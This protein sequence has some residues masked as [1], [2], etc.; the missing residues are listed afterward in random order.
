MKLLVALLLC[1]SLCLSGCDGIDSPSSTSQSVNSQSSQ[2]PEDDADK[3]LEFEIQALPKEH[4]QALTQDGFGWNGS[5]PASLKMEWIDRENLLFYMYRMDPDLSNGGSCRIFSYNI[6]SGKVYLM[7]EYST[8]EHNIGITTFQRDGIPYA[9]FNASLYKFDI[10]NH[11]ASVSDADAISEISRDGFVLHDEWGEPDTYIYDFLKRAEFLEQKN[12]VRKFQR[13]P[14]ERFISWSPDGQYI[15]YR[16]YNNLYEAYTNSDS[17]A[18]YNSIGEKVADITAIPSVQWCQEPGFLIYS[19]V[20]DG[21]ESRVLFDL[22]TGDEYIL[23]TGRATMVDILIQE[24]NFSIVQF[25]QEG[26]LPGI[27]LLD[28][29]TK[30]T[31]P[32]EIEDYQNLSGLSAVYNKETSTVFLE[33]W[34]NNDG[35][36][37][38][39]IE[40]VLVKIKSTGLN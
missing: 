19:K 7:A 2:L 37:L 6:F 8:E 24:P 18:V 36:S 14:L 20:E 32:I 38:P 5:G 1:I 33:C 11:T 4:W 22:T 29:H 27:Y 25:G 34:M 9:L 26:I 30:N 31:Y 35:D 12:Y 28:H 21:V 23:Y 17:Y 10:S 3:K 39:W 15:L 13:D 40:C 16:R